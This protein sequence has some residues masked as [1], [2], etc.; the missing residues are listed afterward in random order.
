MMKIE[1]IENK[2]TDSTIIIKKSY[3]KSYQ[4]RNLGL[5][6]AT[7]EASVTFKGLLRTL[8]EEVVGSVRRVHIYAS[9]WIPGQTV[10]IVTSP[11]L[12]TMI[13]P[14]H[15]APGT[16]SKLSSLGDRAR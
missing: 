10:A 9:K 14:E 4:A 16:H 5:D 13:L 15:K 12:C 3:G 1:Q 8:T 2:R 7:V 11:T 6:D